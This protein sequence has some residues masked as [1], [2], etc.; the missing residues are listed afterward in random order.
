M[1]KI[2][3]QKLFQLLGPLSE[4]FAVHP[5]TWA[6]FSDLE[7]GLPRGALTEISGPPGG[8]K[9]EWVMKFLAENP[10]TRVA[11]IENNFT[12]YPCRLLQQKVS[13]ERVLFVESARDYLWAAIQILKS[14]LFQV[15]VLGVPELTEVALRRLQIEA[16][17]ADAAVILL[18]ESRT[19][20]GCWP[21][22]VQIE[23]VRGSS[24]AD[25]EGD[26][27]LKI[28]KYPGSPP[29]LSLSENEIFWF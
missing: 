26:L 8:G 14:Q 12:L 20:Q 23:V 4:S 2:S 24:T 3:K 17:K 19:A 6:P 7:K 9:T 28:S 10:T 1:G 25:L 29:L 11:W 27:F 22:A 18:T 21:I 16:E 5:K 15:I 13:L